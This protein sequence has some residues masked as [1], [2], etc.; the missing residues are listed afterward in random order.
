M[1]KLL[2][3][4]SAGL[5]GLGL[6]ACSAA[7]GDEGSRTTGA[8]QYN[9]GGGGSGNAQ[10]GSG[11]SA[12]GGSHA[13]GAAGTAGPG[14]SANAGSGGA[15]VSGGAGGS[16]AGSGVG[17]SGVAG[18]GVG[19]SGV[20][21]AA[22]GGA[23]GS[24]SMSGTF[25]LADPLVVSFSTVEI[26]V[27]AGAEMVKCQ[28]FSNPIGKDA[29]LI[30]TDS[31]MVSS[32]HMFVFHGTSYTDTNSV[33]DC[34][35][36][37]F[38]DLLHMS[39]TPQQ[40]FVFPDGVGRVLPS[41]EGLRV[42][43]HLLNPSTTA[44]TAKVTIT[45]HAVDPSLIQYKAVSLFLNN[46]LLSVP[47]GMSVQTR[48]TGALSQNIKLMGAVSHMHSRAT[49]FSAT[50]STGKTLYSCNSSTGVDCW[51]E[52]S[53]A[54]FTPALDIASGTTFTWSCTYNNTTGKT[55]TFGESANTN[56]MCIFA[57]V[58]YPATA[59]VDLGTS[60]EWVL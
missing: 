10:A 53:P 38:S 51:N 20:G 58:A 26:P 52:P 19:G 22:A 9:P 41:G 25:T 17:G 33:A 49:A 13:G 57:G 43:V 34:S 4:C 40:Q 54:N 59:G 56:E 5:L 14:G 3:W 32:H 12:V 55:L 23:G 39:Q 44:V 1:R 60:L 46:A 18:T 6:M 48:T 29:A 30:E 28:N 24:T 7:G 36:I 35:G 50:T 45:F 42:L 27:P 31:D 11:G 16:S 15:G 37:E 8:S 47:A 21:G 2:S